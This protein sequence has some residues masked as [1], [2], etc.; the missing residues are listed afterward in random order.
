MP[1]LLNGYGQDSDRSEGYFIRK[2]STDL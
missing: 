1:E 2:W